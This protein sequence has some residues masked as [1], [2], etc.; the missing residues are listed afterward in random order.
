[1]ETT[2]NPNQE[3]TSVGATMEPTT[4]LFDAD[5]KAK[6]QRRFQRGLLWLGVGVFLMAL[7]FGINFF[8]FDSNTSFITMMYVLTSVGCLCIL[9]CLADILG[10]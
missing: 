7:S 2:P 1:M 8:L 9:K 3:Y 6:H 10:F 4:P 5:A